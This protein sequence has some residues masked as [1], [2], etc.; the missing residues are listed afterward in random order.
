MMMIR[1]KIW[2]HHMNTR[3]KQPTFPMTL[4]NFS[5]DSSRYVHPGNKQRWIYQVFCVQ[6]HRPSKFQGGP[7]VLQTRN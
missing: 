4:V 2:H 7:H 1:T 5:R 3:E 6:Y